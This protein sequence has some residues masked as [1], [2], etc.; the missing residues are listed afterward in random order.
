MLNTPNF[1]FIEMRIAHDDQRQY[2]S[3]DFEPPYQFGYILHKVNPLVEL[4]LWECG[5]TIGRN[6]IVNTLDY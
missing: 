2:L 5:I 1:K 4:E 3:V 6:I